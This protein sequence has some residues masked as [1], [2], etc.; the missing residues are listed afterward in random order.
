M[1][2]GLIRL[3]SAQQ[4]HAFP[5]VHP[6]GHGHDLEARRLDQQLGN[7]LQAVHLRHVEVHQRE[8]ELPGADQVQRVEPARRL[9]DRMAGLRQ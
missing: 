3:C 2:K 8:R 6:A 9:G 1:P 5:A 7:Q 4:I